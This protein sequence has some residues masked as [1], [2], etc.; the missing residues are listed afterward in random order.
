MREEL[1][2]FSCTVDNGELYIN[3]NYQPTAAPVVQKDKVISENRNGIVFPITAVQRNQPARY[4]LIHKSADSDEIQVLERLI[5]GICPEQ[6]ICEWPDG[7]FL[8]IETEDHR[9]HTVDMR[10]GLC[11]HSPKCHP[12]VDQARVKNGS[13]VQVRANP[14]ASW[15][16]AYALA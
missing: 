14:K 1:N 4:V 15:E 12:N 5:P 6:I 16:S 9:L 3:G 2:D 11:K 8:I 10:T 7:L 13:I